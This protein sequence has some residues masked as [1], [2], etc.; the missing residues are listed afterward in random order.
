MSLTHWL[1]FDTIMWQSKKASGAC[2]RMHLMTGAP[3]VM[4]GTKCPSMT[5]KCSSS[6]PAASTAFASPA[7]SDKS[8]ASMDGLIFTHAS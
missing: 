3:H 5:S 7:R 2:L 1:G 4:L 6:A 8:D